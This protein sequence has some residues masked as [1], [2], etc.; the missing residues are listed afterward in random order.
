MQT[1]GFTS[2]ALAAIVCLLA[3]APEGSRADDVA[4]GSVRLRGGY[5]ANP[6][7]LPGGRGGAFAGVDAA[8]AMGRSDGGVDSA[9]SGELQRADYATRGLAPAQRA[10]VTFDARGDPFSGWTLKSQTSADSID[11]ATTKSFDAVQSLRLAADGDGMRPFVV[12]AL[13]YSRLNETNA[14]LTDFLPEDQR[15]IRV[16]AIPGIKAAFGHGDIGASVN[17]SATRYETDPDLFGYRRR[18]E[19]VEPFLFYRAESPLADVSLAVSRLYGTWHDPDFSPVR[20]LLFDL[21]LTLRSPDKRWQFEATGR[22]SAADTTFPISPLTISELYS[23]TLSYSEPDR[24][25]IGATARWLRTAYLDAPFSTSI[26]SYGL[27]GRYQVNRDWSVGADVLR[28]HAAALNGERVDSVLATLSLTRRFA[29]GGKAPGGKER[30]EK[31]KTAPA[32]RSVSTPAATPS[33]SGVAI[34]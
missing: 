32:S 31:D 25:R 15:F 19:R 18:N 29:W 8:F 22:R 6:Q 1:G 27:T 17:L 30:G 7:L 34:Y 16:T 12:G 5:D 26:V 11:S 3:L 33:A 23:G 13:R 9:L 10:K 20:A 4:V 28:I 14:I 24:W 2:P 21:G